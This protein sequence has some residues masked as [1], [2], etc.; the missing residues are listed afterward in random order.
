MGIKNYLKRITG[1]AIAV[2]AIASGSAISKT[3]TSH[4]GSISYAFSFDDGYTFVDIKK[5]DGTYAKGYYF[6]SNSVIA[7]IIDNAKRLNQDVTVRVDNETHRIIY[8][9]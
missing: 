9:H 7:T 1:V 6:G 2:T 8:V 5:A 4:T 3:F